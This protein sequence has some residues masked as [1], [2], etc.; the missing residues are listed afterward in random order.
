MNLSHPHEGLLS[1]SI[2]Q[3][4]G[5]LH[6]S[7]IPVTGRGLAAQLTL[8]SGQVNQTLIRLVRLGIVTFTNQP[9]AKLYQLNRESLLA[10]HLVGI[11][12]AKSDVAGWLSSRLGPEGLRCDLAVIFGSFSRGTAGPDSDLDLYLAWEDS[13]LAAFPHLEMQVMDLAAEFF[14]RFGNA[15]NPIILKL[16]EV[17]SSFSEPGGF[18]K[19]LAKDGT[20]LLGAEL[21]EKLKE[22]LNGAR[23]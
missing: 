3:V 13:S 4:I 16:S 5:G 6:Q 18:E 7:M 12:T 9:P 1:P 8:S 10:Q 14:S 11:V 22:P 2:A 15:M 23:I 19:N 21:F 17:E 20:A